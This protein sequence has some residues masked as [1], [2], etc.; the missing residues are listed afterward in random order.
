MMEDGTMGGTIEQIK[1]LRE[2]TAAGVMDTK[3]ALEESD[4][5]LEKAKELLQERGVAKAQKKSEREAAEGL[6]ASYIHTTGKIGA[7][8]EVFCETDF[9]ARTPDFQKLSHELAMQVA[10][11]DPQSAD[12]LLEQEYIR[13][14][15]KTVQDLINEAIAKVGENIRIGKFVRF[16]I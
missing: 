16:Q 8:V 5:D 11:T 12:D 6:V 1:K 9:V 10:A 14:P 7:L 4:G 3:R 13:N 2:E 15:S